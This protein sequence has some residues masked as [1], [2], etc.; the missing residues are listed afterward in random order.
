MPKANI[1]MS[2]IFFIFFQI[3]LYFFKLSKF[4]GCRIF[5][6]IFFPEKLY[7]PEH[8]RK[9][10]INMNVKLN[11]MKFSGK[12]GSR[13]SIFCEKYFFFQEKDSPHRDK[14]VSFELNPAKREK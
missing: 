7:F 10:D 14:K 6:Q 1:S 5:F 4:F 3:F 12:I 2:L 9:N 11:F 8:Y 13:K